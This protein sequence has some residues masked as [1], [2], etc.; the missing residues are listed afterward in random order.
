VPHVLTPLCD[1]DPNVRELAANVLR[2]IAADARDAVPTVEGQ[3]TDDIVAL[4]DLAIP[5]LVERLH[6]ESPSVRDAAIRAIREIGVHDLTAIAS[7]A[8]LL[9]DRDR[10]I[11]ASAAQTL[12]RFGGDSVPSL[13]LPF[14]DPD[15]KVRELA[16]TVLRAI[17][18]DAELAVPALTGR[19]CDPAVSVRSAAVLALRD[20]G[21][22]DAS[23]IFGLAV[24]LHDPDRQVRFTAAETLVRLKADA[25]P[26]MLV[27]LPTADVRAR[28][29]IAKTLQLIGGDAKRAI[30]ALTMLLGDA[31]PAVRNA[32]ALALRE[33]AGEPEPAAQ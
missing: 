5:S 8:A 4:G 24:R 33:V 16:A 20:I 6:D 21:T 1:A 13:L 19:L 26:A 29:L 11:R 28:E 25:V 32:A 23:A 10:E 18:P 30:P 12:A 3:L 7:L 22:R 15:P 14:A 27:Q 31:S 9:A 2:L 17:G